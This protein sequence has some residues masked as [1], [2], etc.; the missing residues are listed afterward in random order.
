MQLLQI[1]TAL[2]PRI[3]MYNWLRATGTGGETHTL[4]PKVT[5]IHET[6]YDKASYNRLN[7][8]RLNATNFRL[9]MCEQ[10]NT[11]NTVTHALKHC[12]RWEQDREAAKTAFPDKTTQDR[13]ICIQT[14][15]N[16]NNSIAKQ[17]IAK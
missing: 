4:I 1:W 9:N 14:M 13:T 15:L 8:C 6:H 16:P 10:C 3:H 2:W 5:S 12:P 11:P 7:K 17:T